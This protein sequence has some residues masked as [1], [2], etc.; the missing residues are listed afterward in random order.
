MYRSPAYAKW[1]AEAAWEARIQAR[2]RKIEGKFKITARFVKPDKRH[3]DLDNLLKALLD[4][5][6]HANVIANDKD[7]DWIEA[8]WVEDG[9]PCEVD[10]KGI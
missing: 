10:I 8:M 2:A 5:L 4:C 3:R 6:Q 1:R 7:C 9:P